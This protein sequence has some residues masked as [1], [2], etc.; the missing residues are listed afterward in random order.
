MFFFWSSNCCLAA[1]GIG[2]L[3]TS[4]FGLGWWD[5]FLTILFFVPLGAIGPALLILIGPKTGLRMMTIT[6][7]SFGLLPGCLIAFV[8]VLTCL[9]WSMI[10]TMAGA[11]VFYSLT[12]ERLPLAVCILMLAIGYLTPPSTNA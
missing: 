11:E 12:N 6:R 4:I 2:T 10:N 7:Y 3:G 1:F 5:S 8:N 9:G